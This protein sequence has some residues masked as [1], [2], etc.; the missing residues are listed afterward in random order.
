MFEPGGDIS[1]FS[2]LTSPYEVMGLEAVKKKV[3]APEVDQGFN[4][5]LWSPI[6]PF[7]SFRKQQLMRQPRQLELLLCQIQILGRYLMRLVV[8]P[9]SPLRRIGVTRHIRKSSTHVYLI[10]PNLLP[11]PNTR[12]TSIHPISL[13]HSKQALYLFLSHSVET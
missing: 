8:S 6:L 13:K 9:L 3:Y 5:S 4:L 2:A 12:N 1:F 11:H 10:R 7:S